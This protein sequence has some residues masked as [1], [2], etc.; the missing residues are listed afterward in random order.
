VLENSRLKKVDVSVGDEFDP[1]IMD[2]V[3]SGQ[4]EKNKVLEIIRAGY[5][6]KGKLVRPASVKVGQGNKT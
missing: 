2:A 5:L 3:D 6:F 1:K 4:G